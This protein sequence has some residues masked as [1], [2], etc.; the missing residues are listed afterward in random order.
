VTLRHLID[1]EVD[2]FDL[3]LQLAPSYGCSVELR[4]CAFHTCGADVALAHLTVALDSA[5]RPVAVGGPS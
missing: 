4:G 1:R 2:A 3:L 5:L